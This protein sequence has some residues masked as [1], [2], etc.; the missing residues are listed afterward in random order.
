MRAQV[1]QLSCGKCALQ[2]G[3]AVGLL[4]GVDALVA[5]EGSTVYRCVPTA[6]LITLVRLLPSVL[7]PGVHYE[8]SPLCSGVPTA[9]IVAVER[10][11]ACMS[12]IMCS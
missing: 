9:L 5:S 11:L 3:A 6:W 8:G 4:A 10:L 1:A 12:A 2:L 7:A